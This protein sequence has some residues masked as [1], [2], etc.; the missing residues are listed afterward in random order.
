MLDG[1]IQLNLL[2][3]GLEY[4]RVPAHEKGIRSI[5]YHPL[6]DILLTAAE[7]GLV[8]LWRMTEEEPRKLMTFT[9]QS[10]RP[11]LSVKFTPDG[12]SFGILYDHEIAVREWQFDRLREQLRT[13]S[14][15]W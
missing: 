1:C 14:L 10:K 3:D 7:D 13:L 2:V 4:W 6:L 9:R 5:A 15:D 8:H 12:N 11:V